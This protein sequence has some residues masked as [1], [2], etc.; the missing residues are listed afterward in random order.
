MMIP[1]GWSG[2]WGGGNWAGTGVRQAKAL[3]AKLKEVLILKVVHRP[4]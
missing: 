3:G 1:G 4:P 2:E